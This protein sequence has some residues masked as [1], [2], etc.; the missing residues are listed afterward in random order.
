MQFYEDIY[1]EQ[2]NAGLPLWTDNYFWLLR[3]LIIYY[4]VKTPII[5]IMVYF[6]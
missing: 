4:F 5:D 3:T 2:T 1:C 6:C